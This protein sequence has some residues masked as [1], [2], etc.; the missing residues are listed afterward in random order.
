MFD[1]SRA[2]AHRVLSTVAALAMLGSTLVAM[3]SD[4][5][6]GFSVASERA[7][8]VIPN[9]YIVT[10]EDGA[11]PLVAAAYLRRQG[12]D[13][14]RTYS[15]VMNG[16]AGMIPPGLLPRLVDHPDVVS[17]EP[18]WVITAETTTQRNPTWGLDRV[19]Q[20]SLPLDGAFT[21]SSAGEGVRLYVVDSG[22]RSTH[23]EFSGRTDPGYDALK[24]R[25]PASEDCYSHGT[26]VAGVAAGKTYGIAKA[27]TIV[28]V[29]I[30]D[31]DG[32]SSGSAYA[33]ALDWILETHPQ[34]TPGVIN[35][36]FTASANSGADAYAANMVDNG[37]VVAVAAGNH[38]TDACTRSPG[39]E[40]SVLTV[41]AT[42][43]RDEKASY[44]NYGSCVD[45]LAPGSSIDTADINHDNDV[46]RRSGTSISAPFVAGAAAVLYGQQPA[47]TAAEIT[48]QVIDLATTGRLSKLQGSPDRLLYADPAAVGTDQQ[49]APAPEPNEPPVAEFVVSC[50][51]LDCGFDGS[52]SSDVDGEVVSYAW[53]FG[54]GN[55]A[56]GK[57]V[58]HTYKSSGT[59]TVTLTVTDDQGATDE[60]S[61]NV[62]VDEQA[63]PAPE[64]NEPPVA[65]FVVSC[66]DLDCGFDGSG[67]SDV[68]GE[69]VSYAWTFG[70]GN[71][72]TG[73]KVAHTYK[74]SGTYTVTLTVTD[75]QGATDEKSRNVTVE[76]PATEPDA[77]TLTGSVT[78]S[79]PN[80]TSTVAVATAPALV[81][82]QIEYTW[83][84]HRGERGAGFCTTGA[85]GTC[86]FK[87]VQLHNRDQWITYTLTAPDSG[88]AASLPS[89]TLTR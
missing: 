14:D 30:F 17:V 2:V 26:A 62:T 48:E 43:N 20:R 46:R 77:F 88:A 12:A 44:S 40:P 78:S 25:A 6:R 87:S 18:D 32:K 84:S 1:S 50:S 59:Y 68:D 61:R 13:I 67:S 22:I 33:T 19:D 75:D 52:G 56:T 29:N 47:A 28:P 38:D 15:R 63:A 64:P 76:Q 27:A 41:G 10:L 34:G 79:G 73:K 51:D 24:R 42:T 37:L 86:S 16:L 57:K 83:V 60:K 49:A 35:M 53:T 70:D 45:L 82:E 21:Y 9:H 89:I 80:W 7:G 39:R 3:S 81:D 72:A 55:V 66:S 58:A 4:A 31:C 74:S 8:E 11:D 71:V 36:S 85:H 65:E 54:D 69:V 23:T 5:S